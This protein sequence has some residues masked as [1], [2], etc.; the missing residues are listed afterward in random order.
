MHVIM[1]L[2]LFTFRQL[3]VLFGKDLCKVQIAHLGV[4]FSI[5]C[6]LFHEEAEVRGQW[7]LR[8]VW[9]FLVEERKQS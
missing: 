3:L 4:K 7:L 8:E 2:H 5:L 1:S 6:S 9:V